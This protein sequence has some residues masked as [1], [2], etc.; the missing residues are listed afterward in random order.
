[1]KINHLTAWW[2]SLVLAGCGQQA[3]T[4][5]DPPTA[6]TGATQAAILAPVDVETWKEVSDENTRQVSLV[7][8]CAG[9]LDSLEAAEPSLQRK[10]A[11]QVPWDVQVT[12]KGPLQAQ[13]VW[14]GPEGRTGR[15]VVDVLCLNEDN[16]RCWRFAYASEGERKIMPVKIA[17]H[18]PLPVSTAWPPGKDA[19]ERA[20]SEAILRFVRDTAGDK[21][22]AL[23]TEFHNTRVGIVA[24]AKVPFVC[25]QVGEPGKAKHR[26][27]AFSTGRQMHL[28][29]EPRDKGVGEFCD[30][31]Q[32]NLQWYNVSDANMSGN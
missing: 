4:S 31:E 15:I 23:R 1:M 2:V 5:S 22:S 18:P 28:L 25:G 21:L 19:Q 32:A 29:I 20:D 7:G 11:L 26:F 30:V 10:V 3:S 13:C 8:M 9:A 27:A 17:H 16:D 12:R 14:T 24:D 6:T